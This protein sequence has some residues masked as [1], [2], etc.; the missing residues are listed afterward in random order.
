[1]VKVLFIHNFIYLRNN[2]IVP[3][4]Q[5]PLDGELEALKHGELLRLGVA[6]VARVVH[7]GLVVRVVLLHRRRGGVEAATPD[8][9]LGLCIKEIN[10]KLFFLRN[11][12]R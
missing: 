6:G 2:N 12:Y 9:H 8:L 4:W 5:C 1:M 11:Q 10:F 3:V 7:D